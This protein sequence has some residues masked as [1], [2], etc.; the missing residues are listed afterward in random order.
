MI[1]AYYL[2]L[3]EHNYNNFAL[4]FIMLQYFKKKPEKYDEI[5]AAKI[6][7]DINNNSNVNTQVGNQIIKNNGALQNSTNDNLFKTSLDLQDKKLLFEIR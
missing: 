6:Q 4:I 7:D 1:I 5:Y 2:R 3:L